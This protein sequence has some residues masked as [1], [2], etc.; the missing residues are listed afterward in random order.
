MTVATARLARAAQAAGASAR[1]PHRRQQN[2][3]IPWSRPGSRGPFRVQVGR[4]Q[5]VLAAVVP[6]LAL[7]ALA[8][9]LS[10]CVPGEAQG[11]V[12]AEGRSV[13]F[14]SAFTDHDGVVNGPALDPGDSAAPLAPC[15]ASLL[16]SGDASIMIS[17]AFPGYVCRVWLTA[18]ND[19]TLPIQRRA[20]VFTADPALLLSQ[21]EPVWKTLAPGKE[22]QLEF[23]IE[24]AMQ[25]KPDAD[26]VFSIVQPF[27]EPGGG[28]ALANPGA[29]SDGG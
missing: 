4:G 15:L 16:A 22:G 18:R 2:R 27:G 12:H 19:S 29:G 25:A 7:V 9:V 14:I 11:C 10:A 13:R 6:A 23:R 28:Q 8:L 26:Y 3:G 17:N 5:S 24:V 21:T 20:A 1:P